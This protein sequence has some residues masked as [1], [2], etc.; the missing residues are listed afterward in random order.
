MEN[1]HKFRERLVNVAMDLLH[2]SILLAQKLRQNDRALATS[3]PSA[4]SRSLLK[5]ALDRVQFDSMNYS[6]RDGVD[7]QTQKLLAALASKLREY[8]LQ[9]DSSLGLL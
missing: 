5:A 9:H 7:Q 4:G 1:L 6:S 2:L 8:L 3:K